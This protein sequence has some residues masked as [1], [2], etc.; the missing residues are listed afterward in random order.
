[1]FK[2]MPSYL[3][4]EV[5]EKNYKLRDKKYIQNAHWN[6]LSTGVLE[7]FKAPHLTISELKMR[8]DLVI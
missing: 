4:D 6:T 2:S 5:D 1:M 3:K 7:N 8:K